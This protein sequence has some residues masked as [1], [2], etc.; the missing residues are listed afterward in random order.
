MTRLSFY[1]GHSA[2]AGGLYTVS[3]LQGNVT[4]FPYS[5]RPIGLAARL[6]RQLAKAGVSEQDL[7][8]VYVP[9]G[10]FTGTYHQ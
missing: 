3:V 1:R 4:V 6:L 7:D 2:K 8:L 10:M 5:A 9:H